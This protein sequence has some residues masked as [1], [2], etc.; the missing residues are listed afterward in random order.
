MIRARRSVLFVPGSN[1]RAMEKARSLDCDVVALDLEDAVASE[2]KDSAR[3][4]VCEA[5]AA[6]AFGA[7]EVAV[8]INPLS[9]PHG[10]ADML[11]VAKAHPDAVILPKV[12]G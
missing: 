10:H 5:V 6:K 2:A 8:R 3:K 11:A 4:T 7:R 9:S 1:A 12:S